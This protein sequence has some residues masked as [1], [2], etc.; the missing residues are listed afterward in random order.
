MPL[1]GS[2]NVYFYPGVKE[3]AP[4][5]GSGVR[6]VGQGPIDAYIIGGITLSATLSASDGTTN[7]ELVSLSQS[8]TNLSSAFSG[9]NYHIALGPVDV[10]LWTNLA[11]TLVNNS[12]NNLESGSVEFSPNNNNWETDWDTVTFASSA[13]RSMQILG[14]SRRWLRVR[15][16]SSG[17]TGALTGSLD[18]FLHAQNG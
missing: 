8:I 2:A 4:A 11:I 15:A 18:A 5:I 13:T 6:A 17:G 1:S 10:S 14:N 9:A 3:A 12:S 7:V 16:I